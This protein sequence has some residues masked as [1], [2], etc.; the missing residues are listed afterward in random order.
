MKKILR[1]FTKLLPHL[2]LVFSLMMLTFFVIDCINRSMAFLNNGMTK[3]L[4]C[5]FSVLV[6]ISS[7]ISILRNEK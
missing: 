1:F 5:V 6:L 2:T 7:V 3:G 4:L